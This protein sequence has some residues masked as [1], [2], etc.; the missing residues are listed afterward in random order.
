MKLFAAE[1]VKPRRIQRRRFLFFSSI[2]VLTSLATWFMADWLWRDGITG[3]EIAILVLFVIL[4][5]H[6]ATGFCLAMVGFYVVNRGGDSCRILN[7]VD[8]ESDPA[9]VMAPV[10]PLRLGQP[11][12]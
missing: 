4:F 5:A 3:L 7:S 10:R 6:I 8:W 12:G 1:E 2:F 9:T 11:I